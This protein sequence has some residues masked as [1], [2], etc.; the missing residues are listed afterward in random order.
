MYGCCAWFGCIIQ[1]GNSKYVERHIAKTL[2]NHRH[3]E[4]RQEL[5]IILHFDRRAPVKRYQKTPLL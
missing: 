2:K 1:V 4:C 5:A 3:Y